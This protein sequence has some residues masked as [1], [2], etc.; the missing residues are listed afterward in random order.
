MVIQTKQVKVDK[1]L[2]D[3]I[4]EVVSKTLRQRGKRVPIR[5]ITRKIAQ[6]IEEN[7]LKEELINEFVKF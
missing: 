1:S 2:N 6:M 4:D 7:K 3:I 5:L